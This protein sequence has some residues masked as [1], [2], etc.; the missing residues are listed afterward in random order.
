MKILAALVTALALVGI[1]GAALACDGY[2]KRSGDT[3]QADGKIVPPADKT[4]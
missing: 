1:G 4:S 2:I 3:A